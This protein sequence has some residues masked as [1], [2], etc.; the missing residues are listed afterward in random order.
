L[1]L[2]DGDS[3]HCAK[4]CEGPN[5]DSCPFTCELEPT[6]ELFYCAP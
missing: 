1:C 6:S 2:R 5:D 4:L 3:G